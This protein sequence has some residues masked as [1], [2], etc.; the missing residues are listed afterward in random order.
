MYAT[1]RGQTHQVNVLTVLHGI[2]VCTDDFLVLQ[3]RT[4]GTCTVNLHQVLIYDTTCTDVE[5]THLGVAH[6]AVG[7][8]NVLAA[9]QQLAAGILLPKAVH[10]RCGGVENNVTLTLVTYSPTIEDHQKCFLC[11]NLLFFILFCCYP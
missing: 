3:D 10:I 1:I 4:V 8:T 5:V 2:F 11:H 6:L 7:Q 9:C